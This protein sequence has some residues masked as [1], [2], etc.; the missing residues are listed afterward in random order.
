MWAIPAGGGGGSPGGSNLQIQYNNAGAFDGLT[1]V[2]V[3]ARIQQFTTV[4]TGAVPAS[5]T[6]T[7]THFLRDDGAWAIPAGGGGGSPGGSNLQ[8]QYNNAGAFGGLTDVQVTARIQPFTSSLSGATPASGGGT[9]D[10]LRSDATFANTLGSVG[11][12]TGV[13]NLAGNTSGVV[14]I[15]PQAAAGN[16]IFGLP[17]AAGEPGQLLQGQSGA[18]LPMFWTYTPTLGAFAFATGA[19]KFAGSVSGVVT[20]QAQNSAGTYNFNL[21]TTVGAAGQFLTSQAGGS[22]PM[23][24]TTGL[25][26]PGVTERGGY[27]VW[28]TTT[29][30]T[31]VD[32]QGPANVLGFGA[33][34]T[35]VADS[36]TAFNNAWAVTPLIYVPR[37][38]YKI[39]SQLVAPAQSGAGIIGDGPWSTNAAGSID[40]SGWTSSD[41]GTLIS[42]TQTTLDAIV[43]HTGMLYPTYVGFTLLRTSQAT[44]GY[45]LN[46][47]PILNLTVSGAVSGTAGVVRLTVNSIS[48]AIAA[49]PGFTSFVTGLYG[50]VSG[51]NGTTE[52]N[53]AWT[54]TVVDNTH[55]ELQTSSFVHAYTSGGAVVVVGLNDR[56]YLSNLRFANH[57]IGC[58]MGITGHSVARD[59]LCESNRNSGFELV[60]QWQ[61]NNLFS[62]NNGGY[63]FLV[64]SNYPASSGQWRGWNTFNNGNYGIY[65]NGQ[66]T[67]RRI[68]GIR[69]SDCFIGGDV[70]AEINC[71]SFGTNPHQFTNIHCEG[72]AG[73]N[74]YSFTVNNPT[75]LLSNSVG[76]TAGSTGNGLAFNC[77][78]IMISNCDFLGN[79]STGSGIVALTGAVKASVVSTRVNGFSNN[80]LLSTAFAAGLTAASV[81]ACDAAGSVTVTCATPSTV[82][83]Y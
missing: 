50:Q 69:L 11:G 82:G 73:V 57:S 34:P 83:N 31:V 9:L 15:Q 42:V 47:N 67:S 43:S 28:N 51:V 62:A 12:G 19:L 30:G 71:D 5:G 76:T 49:T 33:D 32:G 78:S 54:F 46:M 65:I 59:I 45:G 1:D 3:T 48:A 79:S 29:G 24:W 13:L 63:G 60:G 22:S 38:K 77:P 21:P 53:G 35:G 16:Y 72:N 36:A 56:A 66:S 10:F 41:G 68:E 40:G 4:L 39:G 27:P 74:A 81:H 14:T 25:T 64:D 8:I 58:Y 20:V 37:G 7:A 75:I 17:T 70:T 44:N 2:Q 18:G 52:A 61:T 55:I 80:I 6:A 23:T 26:G